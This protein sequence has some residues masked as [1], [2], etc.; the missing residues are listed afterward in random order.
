MKIN[1][2]VCNKPVD[3]F[4]V[5]RCDWENHTAITVYCHGA[6]EYCT[7]TDH[8]IMEAGPEFAK[9]PEGVAFQSKLLPQGT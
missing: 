9:Y 5:E 1:C 3:R 8:F 6:V 2:A 4:V 7:V